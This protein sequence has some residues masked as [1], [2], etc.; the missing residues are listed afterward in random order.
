MTQDTN[1]ASGAAD[2]RAA[3]QAVVDRWY[4]P[5]WKDAPSTAEFIGRLR[6]ALASAPTPACQHRI[7][8]ARNQAIQSGYMCKDCGA[9]FAAGDHGT[10]QQDAGVLEDAAR[11]LFDAGWK[12]AARFCDRDDVVADGII[13]FGA[14]PQF[15]AAFDAAM[16]QQKAGE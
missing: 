11:S 2:L 4:T 6:A 10:P 9:M 13:G 5:L 16:A 3:A 8:D 1:T 15:E 7:V 12:A 14:C